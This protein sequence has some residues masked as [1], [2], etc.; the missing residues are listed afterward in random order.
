MVDDLTDYVG[1]PIQLTD[2][3]LDSIVFGPHRDDIDWIRRESLLLRRTPHQVRALLERT[4]V[5]AATGPLRIPADATFGMWSRVAVPTRWHG[6]TY[7]F[8]WILDADFA[9]TEH[10]LQ[11]A[12]DVGVEMGRLLH[13][14]QRA[15]HVDA[16]R[17]SDLVAAPLEVRQRAAA[18]L[19]E[20]GVIAPRSPVAVVVL[21]HQIPDTPPDG[22]DAALWDVGSEALPRAVLRVV[23]QNHSVLLVPLPRSGDLE[24]AR[25]AAARLRRVY[26][27]AAHSRVTAVVA[28]ISDPQLELVEVHSA[29]RQA[30]LAARVAEALPEL[31][32]VA[33]WSR[34]GAFRALV[35]IPSD[36][37]GQLALDP[38]LKSIVDAGDPSLLPTLEAYLDSGCD[39]KD[40]SAFLSV[41]RGTV[42]YRLHK[43]ESVSGLNLRDGLDRL[44]LHLSIKLGRLAGVLPHRPRPPMG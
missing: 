20:S 39:V 27:N 34:L 29:Y 17:L 37:V 40:T 25:S 12:V 19:F 28:G 5:F 18:E 4:G 7:G 10:Q 32:P 42:Y 16:S 24:A 26:L 15:R 22:L 33:E 14:M 43:V 13:G 21:Q 44:T 41:H 3:R 23:E 2:V 35:S 11:H 36:Q 8:L 38:V 6:V 30:K 1:L 31:G 9:L